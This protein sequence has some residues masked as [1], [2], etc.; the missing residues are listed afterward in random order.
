MAKAPN[1]FDHEITLVD[2]QGNRLIVLA[3][4]VSVTHTEFY[5]AAQRGMS[6]VIQFEMRVQEYSGQEKIVHDGIMYQTLRPYAKKE[7]EII[8]LVCKRVGADAGKN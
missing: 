3:D 7:T 5:R 2:H 1:T 6:P 4:V 8:E